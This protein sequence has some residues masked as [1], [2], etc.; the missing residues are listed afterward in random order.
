MAE[1]KAKLCDVKTAVSQIYDG[2]RI[3]F[4]GFAVYNKPMA[5]VHEMIRAKKRHLTIVGVANSIDVD[6]LVGA[7]CVDRVETSYMGLEKFGL[8][9]NFRRAVQE[10]KIKM[11]HYPE[12]ISWDRFRAS[13][14]GLSF[15]PTYIL[16]GN[17]VVKYNDEIVPFSDPITGKPMW[18]VPAASPDFSL[19]HMW[20][21]D[22][23]GNM[24]TQQR[25]LN[26]QSVDMIVSRACK[27]VIATVGKLVDTQEIMKCPQ[28][29]TIPSFRTLSVSHVPHGSHPT[30]NLD[31]DGTDEIH[32][33]EY[34]KA[35]VSDESFQKYLDKYVYGVRDHEEYL[36]LIG[37]EQIKALEMEED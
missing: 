18:A 8:C 9:L 11:V 6:M 2:A 10:G 17:D 26:P 19:V 5:L 13:Q 20:R 15:W 29:T 3:A 37:R 23:W 25:R 28:M 4:G 24:Q 16:G 1:R 34:A 21:G 27:K 35:S 22:K 30:M 7:G 31:I 14:D 12:L 32:L 33:A 36:D